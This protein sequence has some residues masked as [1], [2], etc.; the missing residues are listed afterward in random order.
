MRVAI[1]HENFDTEPLTPLCSAL[2]DTKITEIFEEATKILAVS[3]LLKAQSHKAWLM[4]KIQ[5]LP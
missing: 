2:I 4:I 5:G 1:K 3:R